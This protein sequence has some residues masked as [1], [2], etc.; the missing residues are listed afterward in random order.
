MFQ[1]A[2]TPSERKST[3]R[4]QFDVVPALSMTDHVFEKASLKLVVPCASMLAS[5]QSLSSNL[6]ASVACT[7]PESVYAVADDEKRTTCMVKRSGSAVVHKALQVNTCSQ[8]ASALVGSPEGGP[9]DL[10]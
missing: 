1:P 6:V 8:L 4:L 10:F 3:T 5:I 2:G 9:E 7:S